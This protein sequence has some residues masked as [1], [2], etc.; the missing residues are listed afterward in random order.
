MINK[1]KEKQ[2]ETL[3]Q[4]EPKVKTKESKE[5]PV[6][7]KEEELEQVR[8]DFQ[9]EDLASEFA[10]TPT[11]NSADKGPSINPNTPA[12]KI[13][14]DVKNYEASKS[15]TLEY[16]DLLDTAKFLIGLFDTALST[17]LNWFAKDTSITAY[18][19][20]ADQKK[21][22]S[23]QLALI[24]GKYQAS[25]KV[26]FTFFIALIVMSAPYAIASV[27]N[28]KKNTK[29]PYNKDKKSA[30]PESNATKNFDEIKVPLKK[31]S[32]RKAGAQPKAN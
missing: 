21:T 23:E 8:I 7:N 31:K 24:L 20:T 2:E 32:K 16:K 19:M 9:D 14:E 6:D 5:I 27:K 29:R 12:D 18:S 10:A 26:E 3:V 4:E 15:G 1:P 28:R 22:L 30:E 25:F 17:A 13:G 11:K